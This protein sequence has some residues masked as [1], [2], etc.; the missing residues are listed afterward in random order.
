MTITDTA[1]RGR[2]VVDEAVSSYVSHDHRPAGRLFVL[3]GGLRARV[4]RL[5]SGRHAA[6][7]LGEQVSGV[8]REVGVR[9][10]I[11]GPA[12]GSPALLASRVVG[13]RS[14]GLRLRGA[15]LAQEDR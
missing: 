7:G 15:A 2:E 3:G 1:A 12:V 14:H 10:Q 5:A 6:G 13:R 11:R 4:R 8:E 9:E